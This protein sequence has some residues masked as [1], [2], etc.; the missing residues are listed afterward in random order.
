MR[1]CFIILF[2]LVL[3]PSCQ[4]EK[5]IE[6]SNQS[7]S[8]PAL[9]AAPTLTSTFPITYPAG[10][11]NNLVTGLDINNPVT[12]ENNELCDINDIV[13][14]CCYLQLYAPSGT[15]GFSG[16]TFGYKAMT[17]REN[18]TLWIKVKRW[19]PNPPYLPSLVD[20]WEYNGD[21]RLRPCWWAGAFGLT[22]GSTTNSPPGQYVVEAKILTG[23]QTWIPP[24]T[25]KPWLGGYWQDDYCASALLNL[26][27]Q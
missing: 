2:L 23:T 27:V 22:W 18:H 21:S 26:T 3:F 20:F 7:E 11:T 8:D 16:L 14:D 24:S 10:I 5:T 9:Q 15:V 12:V 13:L 17:C 1:Y 25:F 6:K 4:K 19:V